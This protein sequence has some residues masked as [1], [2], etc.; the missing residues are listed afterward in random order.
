MGEGERYPP[1]QLKKE[2]HA[3]VLILMNV[4]CPLLGKIREMKVPF[5]AKAE[6]ERKTIIRVEIRVRRISF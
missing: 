6:K 2:L 3:L 5:Q 1:L 4:S